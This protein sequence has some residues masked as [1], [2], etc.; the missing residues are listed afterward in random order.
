M[1]IFKAGILLKDDAHVF[2]LILCVFL[3]LVHCSTD[4]LKLRYVVLA[5][6]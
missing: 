2:S 6:E 1:G 4:E 5:E 3:S